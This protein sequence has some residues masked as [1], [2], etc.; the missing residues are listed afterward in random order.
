MC[1]SFPL[2][3]LNPS[4][5]LHTIQE[6]CTCEVTIGCAVIFKPIL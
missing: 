4:P 1:G 5:Y 2:G 6:L 3:D